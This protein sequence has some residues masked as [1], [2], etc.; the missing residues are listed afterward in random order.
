MYLI[1]KIRNG[2]VFPHVL[3]KSLVIVPLFT[4]QLLLTSCNLFARVLA[5]TKSKVRRHHP[6]K[7]TLLVVSYVDCHLP[8]VEKYG[9]KGRGKDKGYLKLLHPLDGDARAIGIPNF[10]PA[11]SRTHRVLLEVFLTEFSY[12]Q[13]LLIA[14]RSRFRLLR[15]ALPHAADTYARNMFQCHV[16]IERI[17]VSHGHAISLLLKGYR[18]LLETTGPSGLAADTAISVHLAGLFSPF[19]NMLE[20][21]AEVYSNYAIAWNERGQPDNDALISALS[22]R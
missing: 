7:L 19:I 22:V 8:C 18:R 14:C 15:L 1:P 21:L 3:V 17:L 9:K 13:Y 12:L 4:I 2:S 16:F 11:S 20:D 10:D 5:F 6:L